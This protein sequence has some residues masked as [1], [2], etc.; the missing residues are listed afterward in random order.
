MVMPKKADHG[1]QSPPRATLHQVQEAVRTT[2]AG[3]PLH[4]YLLGH[5]NGLDVELRRRSLIRQSG[6]HL[7]VLALAENAGQSSRLTKRLPIR[8]AREVGHIMGLV[9]A[10]S[11]SYISDGS[12]FRGIVFV[13]S[14]GAVAVHR[15]GYSGHFVSNPELPTSYLAKPN[16]THSYTM[17]GRLGLAS[18]WAVG[19]QKYCESIVLGDPDSYIDSQS[20]H[21]QEYGQP[22]LTALNYTLEQTMQ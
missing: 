11:N 4:A 20:W 19:Y 8:I 16:D 6:Q 18:V 15:T 1:Q 2:T 17:A 14:H 10:R 7:A 22:E 3:E 21:T 12:D 9:V 5:H 13:G